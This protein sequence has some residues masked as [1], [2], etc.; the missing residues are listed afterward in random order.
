MLNAPKQTQRTLPPVGTHIARCIGLIYLG[1]VKTEWQGQEKWLDKV[2]LTWELPEELHS[3]KDGEDK[4]PFVVSREFT[5][6][7]GD[8]S[9]L[10]PIVSGIVGDIP[11]DV[12]NSFDHE[13]L[14]GTT[15]LLTLVH[16]ES[17]NGKYALIT[18]TAPLM[19]SMKAPEA[20]N[21]SKILTYENWDQE[22]FDSLPDFI[23]DKMKGSKQ[24]VKKFGGSGMT[25]DEANEELDEI[26]SGD[27]PF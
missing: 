9:N 7:M 22:Y 27:I 18:T 12:R 25:D 13:E 15:C 17:P 2:R 3:F 14:V 4:K 1:T 21:E 19:K 8:K 20:I 23:K 10:Y 11:E 24:Y 5:L 26:S 16:K 6:S